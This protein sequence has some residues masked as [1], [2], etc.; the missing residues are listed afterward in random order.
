ASPR[1]APAGLVRGAGRQGVELVGGG[2]GGDAA[3][4]GAAGGGHAGRPRGRTARAEG[5]ELRGRRALRRDGSD[6]VGARPPRS[7]AGARLSAGGG[8]RPAARARRD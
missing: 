3:G 5:G 1:P 6:D 8:G 2:G 4:G 7:P